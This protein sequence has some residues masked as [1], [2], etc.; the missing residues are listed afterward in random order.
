MG[1]PV[2]DL[3]DEAVHYIA[4]GTA[5]HGHAYLVPFTRDLGY[6]PLVGAW[7]VSTLGAAAVAGRLVMGPLSDRI[8]RR[9][10]LATAMV[11][12]A[13]AFGGFA[14]AIVVYHIIIVGNL[15]AMA[16]LFVPGILSERFGSVFAPALRPW[17]LGRAQARVGSGRLGATDSRFGPFRSAGVS[18]GLGSAGRVR[19]SRGCF[20]PAGF[21]PMSFA[22][23]AIRA[24]CSMQPENRVTPT[25][26]GR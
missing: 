1:L 9:P 7:C 3:L 19:R 17:R 15:A 18:F 21:A 4:V 10:T 24:A 25:Q 8:G 16:G 12:Q 26:S 22:I 6:S 23:S 11:L 14:T 13:A 2:I 20:I 5:G